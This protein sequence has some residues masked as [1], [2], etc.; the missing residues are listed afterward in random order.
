MRIKAVIAYD[1]TSFLGFQRQNYT[2]NTI[3]NTIENA[4]RELN[5]ETK[6]IAS[7]RTDAG[8][9]ALKQTIHF[10]APDFWN[11]T[12]KLK[13]LLNRRCYEKGIYF[14][15]LT[16]VSNDFHARFSAKKRSY[17]YVIK[18][19][20]NV[21]ERN[22]VAHYK[23]L[24]ETLLRQALHCFEGTHDFEYFCKSGSNVRNFTR[25]IFKT[26][27]KQIGDYTLCY[28]QADGFLRTQ[29]RLMTGAAIEVALGKTDF[30]AIS[31][32]LN[33]EHKRFNKP[34]KSQGLY[35]SNIV[36]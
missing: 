4:L 9:H 31:K 19:N 30:A 5:I 14:K 12:E 17:F 6:I 23:G 15:R 32:Q 2:Q 8:V 13:T 24:D 3:A 1:G 28:F 20:P 16:S 18:A 36:Y 22:Y 10:D 25:T 35:L 27:V 11:D 29:I 7:G 33:K 21:F 34:A 26:S